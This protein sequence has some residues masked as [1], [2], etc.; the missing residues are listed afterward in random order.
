MGNKSVVRGEKPFNVTPLK[1]RL[2]CSRR[3]PI[4]ILKVAFLGVPR[5]HLYSIEVIADK[6]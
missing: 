6:D 4:C 1:Q 3:D 2:A 5:P